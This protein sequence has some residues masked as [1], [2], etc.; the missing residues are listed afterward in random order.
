MF[1]LFDFPNEILHEIL[2]R[3]RPRDFENFTLSCKFIRKLAG[4]RLDEHWLLKKELSRIHS[5]FGAFRGYRLPELLDRFLVEPRTADYINNLLVKGW[6]PCWEQPR[7]GEDV[8]HRQYLDG[9]MKAFEKAVNET[10]SVPSA[11]K[12]GWISRLHAGDEDPLIGLLVTRLHCLTSIKLELDNERSILFETLKSIVKDPRSLSLS[13]LRDVEIY[14]NRPNQHMGLAVC[15]AALPSVISLTARRLHQRASGSQAI[16]FFNLPP[17]SSNIRDLVLDRCRSSINTTSI[18]IAGI[19]SLRYFRC[20][21]H[22]M[23]R[24]PLFANLLTTLQQHASRSLEELSIRCSEDM[25]FDSKG[26]SLGNY[27]NLRILTIRY[28]TTDCKLL[29]SD[30][31]TTFLPPSLEILNFAEHYI[32]SFEWLQAMVMSIVNMKRKTIR[33]LRQLNVKETLLLSCGSP[34]WTRNLCLK[35][36][37]AGIQITAFSY[38]DLVEDLRRR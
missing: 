37:E 1:P 28:V 2:D 16:S 17:H 29:T 20:D 9:R 26:S 5:G 13:Q 22:K 27:T 3:V 19:R 15:F 25:L 4:R 10:D 6:H 12:E 23:A 18:L 34:S 24:D 11:D 33:G 14:G 38:H 31:M 7:E 21:S 36:A 8:I 30:I 35:A 32:N